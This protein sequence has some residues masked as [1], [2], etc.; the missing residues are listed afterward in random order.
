[1]GIAQL[2]GKSSEED[3]VHQHSVQEEREYWQVVVAPSKVC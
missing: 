2:F 1:M 3:H